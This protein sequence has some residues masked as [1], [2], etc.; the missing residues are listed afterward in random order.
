M[1]R[2]RFILLSLLGLCTCAVR[3]QVQLKAEIDSVEIAIGQQT[4]VTLQLTA[5]ANAHVEWPQ[6]EVGA[7]MTPGVEV[8][9]VTEA[10]AKKVDDGLQLLERRYLLTSF[11]DTL[12]Y[13]PPLQV[14]VDGKKY[15]TASLALKVYTCE[16]DTLHPDHFFGP[17]G[18]QDNPFRWSD[19]STA[20]WF[21]I[22]MLLLIAADYWLYLR[23][24]DNKP[25]VKSLKLV[26]RLL[27]HQKAR[28]EIE[29]IKADRMPADENS[30]EY[31]TRLTDTLR[32][33][34]EE[35][36]GFSAMEMTSSEII[37]QL[38]SVGDEGLDELRRLFDTADLVKFAKYS[39][40]LGENDQNLVSAIDFINRTKIDKPVEPVE[41]KPVL[42]AEEQRSQ[43]ER[44]ALKWSIWGIGLVA[45]LL[46]VYVCYLL[47]NLDFRGLALGN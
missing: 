24:R 35:R 3:S 6:L 15:E 30:K 40:L 13:L 44:R 14:K 43:K 12:Y 46:F 45:G 7:M 5:P 39:T 20:F 22:L 34:I 27:P 25:V 10:E 31:Y 37:E 9:G 16:V 28:R 11:D 36:Y 29:Q 38:M 41:Q 18:V 4:C 19:Y 47:F 2:L 17:K 8:L 42:T 32:R 1:K 23:L 26:R 33:Y 21:S